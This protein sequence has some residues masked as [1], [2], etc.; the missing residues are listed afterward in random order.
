[1]KTWKLSRTTKRKTVATNFNEK[2]ITCKAQHF[3]IFL[4]FSL[5][6]IILL[7]AINIYCYLIK[8]QVKQKHSL[9]EVLY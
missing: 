9:R 2:N 5:I 1:M 6:N 7:I 3:Y 4:G 8:H